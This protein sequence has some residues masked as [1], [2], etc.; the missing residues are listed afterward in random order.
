MG[1]FGLWA[2]FV[3]V[4]KVLEIELRKAFLIFWS[5]IMERENAE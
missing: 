4:E 5:V 3:A 2:H 1:A